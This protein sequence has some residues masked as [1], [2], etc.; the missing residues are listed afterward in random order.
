MLALSTILAGPAAAQPALDKR[1]GLNEFGAPIVVT[2]IEANLL[3][4]VARAAGVPMGIEV[5]TGAT[6]GTASKTLTGLTVRAALDVITAVDPRYEWREMNGVIVL[7]SPDA[8]NRSNHPLDAPVEP[9]HLGNLRGRNA[10]SIIAA[11][12]GGPQYRDVQL[13]DTKRFSLHFAGGTVLELLNAV[14]SAHGRLAWAFA[15][16]GTRASIFPFVVT[17]FSGFSGAGCG[18]PGHP[19]E[20]PLDLSTYLDPPTFAAGGSS[21]VLDRIVGN[22]PNDGT[23]VVN[24]PYPAA[25]SDLAKATKVPMGIELLGPGDHPVTGKITATGRTLRDVLTAMVLIDPRYDWREMDG[26]VVIRPVVAWNDPES[27]FFRLVAPVQMRAV[28][29]QQAVE[30]LAREV[31][32]GYPLGGIPAGKRLTLDLPQGTLLDLANAIL[33]THGELTWTLEPESSSDGSPMNYPYRLTFGVMGGG[34]LGFGA[35]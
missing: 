27:L 34:G 20:Q 21:A 31:G 6:H 28:A 4:V 17:L 33:R 7:R 15:A 29:L 8:W 11:V 32:Y 26:V 9:L 23:L 5:A 14:T 10:L 12:L 25:V 2:A 18:V 19:P 35:R 24:G 13:G 22:G 30:R 16:S 1:I 3:G